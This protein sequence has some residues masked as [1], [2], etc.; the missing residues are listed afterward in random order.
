M[1]RHSANYAPDEEAL[2]TINT[3]CDLW[4]FWHIPGSVASGSYQRSNLLLHT[5]FL[6]SPRDIYRATGTT[7]EPNGYQPWPGM[8]TVYLWPWNVKQSFCIVD[9]VNSSLYRAISWCLQ[10]ISRFW[11]GARL[12]P[13]RYQSFSVMLDQWCSTLGLR[14]HFREVA[15]C[16][17]NVQKLSPKYYRKNCTFWKS[18][19][20]L[21][22]QL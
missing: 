11:Y 8:S 13:V 4:S 20:S 17:T 10:R 1:I 19:I 5:A 15:D 12:L 9:I 6:Y 14:S 21:L 3:S 22:Q 2:E 16:S 7:L 18:W